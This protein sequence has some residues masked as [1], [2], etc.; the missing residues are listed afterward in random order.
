M[1]IVLDAVDY[2]DRDLSLD[3]VPDP[4]IVVSGGHEVELMDAE[5]IRKGRFTV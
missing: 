5:H 1:R 3:F 2:E 4:E